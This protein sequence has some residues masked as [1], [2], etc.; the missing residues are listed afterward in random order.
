M[1][2]KEVVVKWV[3]LFNEGNADQIAELYHSDAIN[4]QVANE[5]VNGKAEIRE[6]FIDEFSSAE[7]TPSLLP[8]SAMVFPRGSQMRLLPS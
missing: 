5:P 2:P 7:M 4:H 1:K 8:A 6:M 3:E